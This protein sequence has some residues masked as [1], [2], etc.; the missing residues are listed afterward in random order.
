MLQRFHVNTPLAPREVSEKGARAQQWVMWQLCRG[1]CLLSGKLYFSQPDSAGLSPS[2]SGLWAL[3]ASVQQ[4]QVDL[5]SGLHW[6]LYFLYIKAYKTSTNQAVCSLCLH[7]KADLRMTNLMNA[8][9]LDELKCFDTEMNSIHMFWKTHDQQQITICD[10]L[11]GEQERCERKNTNE[12]STQE[13]H[14]DSGHTRAETPQWGG[15]GE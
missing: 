10:E 2:R 8:N 6:N 3:L 7:L 1:F 13:R 11:P 15:R 9:L 5:S 14:Q 4:R 12:I